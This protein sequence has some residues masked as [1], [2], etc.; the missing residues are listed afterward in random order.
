MPADRERDGRP[1]SADSRIAP[2]ADHAP[3]TTTAEIS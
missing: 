2:G 1:Q 3:T